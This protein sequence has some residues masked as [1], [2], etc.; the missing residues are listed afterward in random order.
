[1]DA[2][3]GTSPNILLD[4][5]ALVLGGGQSS[6]GSRPSSSRRP[7]RAWKARSSVVAGVALGAGPY[8]SPG[9][10][11][12]HPAVTASVAG[13][14]SLSAPMCPDGHGPMVRKTGR[15]G[16]F[17]SCTQYPACRRT[18]PVPLDLACPRCQAPLVVRSARKSGKPFTGCSRY[19]ACTFVAWTAPHT[20]GS[21]G[22]PCLGSEREAGPTPSSKVQVSGG[23]DADDDV[24]F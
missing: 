13:L 9:P 17:Y 3:A 6:T 14:A 4:R 7:R 2:L 20:C 22:R 23:G 18:A 11:V 8:E 10:P 19:P 12:G 1:M 5:A 21:C 16:E 15:T 24:P